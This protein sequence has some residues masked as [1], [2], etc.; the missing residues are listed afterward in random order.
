[1]IN[2]KLILKYVAKSAQEEAFEKLE[3]GIPVQYIIGN[4]DFYG[5]E[6]LVNENVL[7]PRFETET[8]VEKTINYISKYN[9][10]DLKIADLGTGSGCI[11]ITLDKK[12]NAEITCFDISSEALEVTKKNKEKLNS[13]VK[14]IK[15]DIL[16]EIPGKY[17]ILISNPPYIEKNDEVEDIV[18]NNEPNIALFA[19]NNGLLFYEEI[20]KY[21]K[22]V[23][24]K[25]FIIAFEIGYTQGD[26]IKS[27]AQ[28][29]FEN[30]V[31]TV[32]KD[33]TGKNR[34]VFI[35]NE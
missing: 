12:L 20:L 4:V 27:L 17:N 22:N 2:E 26:Y 34:Y 7:I 31:V 29:Y 13:K 10:I 35:I 14:I 32:E 11:G 25:K 24:E 5:Y 9:F 30:A 15:Y 21:A 8:L 33:L 19:D 18:K 6:F 16:N 3:K 1:M 28:S 23:L